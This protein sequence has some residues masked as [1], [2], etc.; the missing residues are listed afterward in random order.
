VAERPWGPLEII[1]VLAL[2]LGTFVVPIIGPIVGLVL[3]WASTRWTHREKK[4]ATLL[5]VLPVIVLAIGAIGLV[6]VRSDGSNTHVPVEE[7]APMVTT[8]TGAPS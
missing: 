6:S 1:A 3:V 4:V 8:D 7:H 2:T 5:T